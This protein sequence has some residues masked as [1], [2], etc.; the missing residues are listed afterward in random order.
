MFMKDDLQTK[1][2][3]VMTAYFNH[4][5]VIFRKTILI[6]IIK[7]PVYATIKQTFYDLNDLRSFDLSLVCRDLYNFPP[8]NLPTAICGSQ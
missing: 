1:S 2:K 4:I 3:P 6:I 7:K 5:K 8:N